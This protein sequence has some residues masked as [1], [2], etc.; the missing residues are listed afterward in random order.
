MA[1]LYASV[2]HGGASGY[3]AVMAICHF[4]PA[5]MKPSALILNVLVSLLAFISYQ[6]KGVFRWELFWP[7]A[8]G[9]IPASF[10]GATIPITDDIYKKLLGLALLIAVL[11]MLMP[12]TSEETPSK[13]PHWGIALAIGAGIGLMSGMLG[14]GGGIVLSPIL[15]LMHWGNMKET[16]AVSS[17]FIFV[18][19]ISGLLGLYSKPVSLAPELFVWV[20]IA[21]FS[22][23]AG[24]YVGAS[25]WPQSRLKRVLAVVLCIACSKLIFT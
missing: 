10:Y 24:A 11:R 6:R 18:N 4:S 13:S 21:F 2:G 9:S 7:F 25:Q 22:G 16:A 19:S 5:V 3:L 20:G 1:F 8:I 12:S 23:L 14:I 17:L 15:L